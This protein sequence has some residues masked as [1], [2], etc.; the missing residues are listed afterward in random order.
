MLFESV[1]FWQAIHSDSEAQT[2][3]EELGGDRSLEQ[4]LSIDPIRPVWI[5][6]YKIEEKIGEGGFSRI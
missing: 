3:A 1:A 5:G 6:P 2:V 4:I